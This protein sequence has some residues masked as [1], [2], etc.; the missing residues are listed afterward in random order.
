MSERIAAQ[1][2]TPAPVLFRWPVRVY[3]EDTDAGGVVYHSNYINF[4]ERARTE[5]LRSHGLELNAMQR[6]YGLIFAVRALSVDYR[7][8]ARLNDALEVTVAVDSVRS[9]SLVFHQTILNESGVLLCDGVVRVVSLSAH[10]FRPMA[11]PDILLAK[12]G[13]GR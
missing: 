11:L 5:Y 8:P 7:R 12:F 10:Q 1:T 4:M 3:Y 9:A 6:D 2:P 13:T